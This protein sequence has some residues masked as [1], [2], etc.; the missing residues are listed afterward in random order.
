MDKLKSIKSLLIGGKFNPDRL[1]RDK[2]YLR[3]SLRAK[4]NRPF[5]IRVDS[6]FDIQYTNLRIVDDLLQNET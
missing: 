6:F 5:A 1:F 4:T 3:I 2:C